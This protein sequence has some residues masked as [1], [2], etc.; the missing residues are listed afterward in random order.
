MGCAS[1]KSTPTLSAP[2]NERER[3]L[4]QQNYSSKNAL[5]A[6][7]RDP[8][9]GRVDVALIDA[10]WLL[11]LDGIPPCRQQLPEKAFFQGSVDIENVVVLAI[12]YPWV[13]R[14][15]PDPEG[16]H[17]RI[18]KH[19]L[20]LYFNL[21]LI[22]KDGQNKTVTSPPA[23]QGKR[24]AIFWDWMSLYQ[25]HNPSTDRTDEQ[26]QSYMRAL[27]NVHLWFANRHTMVWRL[28][29]LPLPRDAG[30]EIKPAST[31]G[32]CFF[33]LA[34][35]QMI[36][37]S[38]RVLNLGV[39]VE[40][41]GS[42]FDGSKFYERSFGQLFGGWEALEDDPEGR[43]RPT[44]VKTCSSDR[45]LPMV[46]SVFD[47]ELKN[48]SFSNR[49]DAEFV[50][51]KY[52]QVYRELMEEST[53]VDFSDC[54]ITSPIADLGPKLE[55]C[56]G[57]LQVLNLGGN[58]LIKGTLDILS[59]CTQLEWLDLRGCSGLTGTLEPLA[60]LEKLKELN[61]YCCQ[62]MGGTLEPLSNL[63]QLKDLNLSGCVKLTG[64]LEPLSSLSQLSTLNLRSCQFTGTVEPLEG[65]SLTLLNLEQCKCLKGNLKRLRKRRGLKKV[66]TRGASGLEG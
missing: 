23:G 61:L 4:S 28:T 6:A 58:P 22:G 10:D 40:D 16:W 20:H 9:T 45:Q 42:C 39:V 35:S 43:S 24:V 25:E 31:R 33:E 5:E 52:A 60:S 53:S 57:R 1:S 15:H 54:H 49:S 29:K 11:Q 3:R 2:R 17:L 44:L 47:E 26:T 38:D 19:F 56:Q 59:A 14:T 37:P 18:M 41:N 64:G 48:L 30:R 55:V 51:R 63:S 34:L 46:P 66:E 36:T 7:R 65:L 12:T 8:A 27:M 50:Q 32:W 13:R 21:D 62:Q